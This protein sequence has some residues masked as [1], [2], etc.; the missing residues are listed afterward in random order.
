MVS[1][2]RLY[3]TFARTRP[4]N[5]QLSKSVLAVLNRF[6]WKVVAIVYCTKEDCFGQQSWEKTKEDMKKVFKD[7]EI[8]VS[9]E[10]KMPMEHEFDK[11]DRVLENIKAKARSEYCYSIK[12]LT[13]I[14]LVL[15]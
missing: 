14:R 3:P 7:N 12:S 15:S 6:S 4:P 2:K 13:R 10:A 1:D 8:R 11:I 5:S 9:Y